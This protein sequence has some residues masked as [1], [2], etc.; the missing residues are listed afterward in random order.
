M[1]VTKAPCC[2]TCRFFHR[3]PNRD[4]G[5]CRR[6]PPVPIGPLILQWAREESHGA[7]PSSPM[8]DIVALRPD[9]WLQPTTWPQNWCG[10]YRVAQGRRANGAASGRALPAE[11]RA[12]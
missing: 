4:D 6:F 8:L 7:E 3:H 5:L 9:C 2:A 11:A 1:P 10:E 12:K